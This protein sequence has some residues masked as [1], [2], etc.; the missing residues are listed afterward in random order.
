MLECVLNTLHNSFS[1]NKGDI[2]MVDSF[3]DLKQDSRNTVEKLSA[4]L[5]KITG[6][7]ASN[8]DEKFWVPSVDK[9]GNGYAVIRFL[10]SP[11]GE[12]APFV[13]LWEHRFKGPT[14]AGMWRNA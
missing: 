3:L 4:Q 5:A 13:R 12:D 1:I 2:I 8:D 6:P 11:K 10:D 9:T 14:V 7:T